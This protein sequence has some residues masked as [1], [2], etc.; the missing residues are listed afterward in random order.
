MTPQTNQSLGS[1]PAPIGPFDWPQSNPTDH[2][3]VAPPL[4]PSWTLPQADPVG[5]AGALPASPPQTQMTPQ[6]VPAPP[7]SPFGVPVPPAL[8][9]LVEHF[10]PEWLDTSKA[11]AWPSAQTSDDGGT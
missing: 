3:W 1:T 11:Q 8:L 2:S 5:S 7:L 9:P 4:A 10:F 6:Q